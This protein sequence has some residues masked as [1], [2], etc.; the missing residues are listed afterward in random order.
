MSP[1]KKADKGAGIKLKKKSKCS[2]GDVKNVINKRQSKHALR[3]QEQSE[4]QPL[5][6]LLHKQT[7]TLP[8]RKNW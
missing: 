1:M 5:P 3:N 6:T 4:L 8:L 7:P 2:K